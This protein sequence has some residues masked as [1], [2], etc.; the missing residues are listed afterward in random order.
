MLV[1]E[2]PKGGY[3]PL[4]REK[5]ERVPDPRVPSG[6]L[7][8]RVALVGLTVAVAAMAWWRFQHQSAPIPIA[9]LPLINLNQ[10]PANDY[11]A[12]GLTG[13]IIRNLSFIDGLAVRSQTSSFVFKGKPRNVREAGKQLEADYILEVP[14]CAPA[15]SC[16]ST[17]SWFV[18]ATTFRYGREGLTGRSPTSSRFR[19]RFPKVSSTACG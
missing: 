3:T 19:M 8:L 7:W 15:T 14:F 2:L 16:G 4:F 18:Y 10:D 17:P 9:V 12:D 6:R 5:V 1:I 11:F 13:E